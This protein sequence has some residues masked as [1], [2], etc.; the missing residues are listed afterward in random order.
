MCPGGS[1]SSGN[2]CNCMGN[3]VT[4]NEASTTTT[5]PCDRCRTNFFRDQ[6]ACMSCPTNAE[7]SFTQSEN[8]C[9]CAGNTTT[10]AGSTSTTTVNCDGENNIYYS[11]KW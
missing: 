8:T 6:S 9:T 5:D 7:R 1:E 3:F 11:K 2:V 10:S 4:M